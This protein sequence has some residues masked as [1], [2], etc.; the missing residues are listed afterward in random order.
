M[1]AA[2][3]HLMNLEDAAWDR[4]FPLERA[5]IINIDSGSDHTIAEGSRLTT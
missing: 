3:L 4:L 5:P 1:A 2:C